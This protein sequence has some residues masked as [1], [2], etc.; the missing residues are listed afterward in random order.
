[1]MA[2]R[3]SHVALGAGGLAGRGADEATFARLRSAYVG[4]L[5]AL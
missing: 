2:E 3:N 4:Q 5:S 1:M